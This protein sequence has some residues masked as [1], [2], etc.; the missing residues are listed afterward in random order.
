MN[1]LLLLRRKF[2][3]ITFIE[4]AKL[5]GIDS[6]L[7]SELGSGRFD[8]AAG[9]LKV[10]SVE[11]GRAKLEATVQIAQSNAYGTLHGGCASLWVDIGGTIALLTVDKTRPGVS[12]ELSTSFHN[13]AK[14]GQT[15]II[16]CHVVK[17][18]KQI[19]WADVKISEK[20]S[21][22]II[23]SGKHVKML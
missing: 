8:S 20:D 18:G 13:A 14:V 10:T 9:N 16:D 11:K 12:L 6:L 21:G 1:K 19:G 15:L 4:K 2:S 3:S 23:C 22:K 17:C 5:Y 7:N